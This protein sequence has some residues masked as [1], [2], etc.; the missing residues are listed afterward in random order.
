M[1]DKPYHV[2]FTGKLSPNLDAATVKSNLVL[3]IGL[4]E[5]KVDLLLSK[6]EVILKRCATSVEAQRLAE[7]FERAGAICVVKDY[8]PAKAGAEPGDSSFIR[9]MNKFIPASGKGR[10][11]ASVEE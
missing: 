10:R 8:S 4:S 11:E 2:V 7:K 3:D 6:G 1:S 9:L 5:A